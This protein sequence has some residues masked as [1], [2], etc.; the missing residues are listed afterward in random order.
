[1]VVVV[2]VVSVGSSGSSGGGGVVVV[3]MV[4]AANAWVRC[5]KILDAKRSAPTRSESLI[6]VMLKSYQS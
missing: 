1:M 2:V 4:A 6:A 3:V 5:R